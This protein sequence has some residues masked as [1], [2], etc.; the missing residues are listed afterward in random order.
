MFAVDP[1][2]CLHYRHLRFITAVFAPIPAETHHAQADDTEHC[3]LAG[4]S[5]DR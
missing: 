3:V 5:R 1:I 2:R 4:Q